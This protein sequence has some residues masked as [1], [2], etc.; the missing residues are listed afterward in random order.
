MENN[1]G[2]MSAKPSKTFL[3]PIECSGKE[4]PFKKWF[5]RTGPI[6]SGTDQRLYDL[7][8]FQIATSGMQANAVIGELW[9]T[10]CVKFSKPQLS[11]APTDGAALF[12]GKTAGWNNPGGTNTGVPVLLNKDSSFTESFNSLGVD[13]V[14]NTIA[15][16]ANVPNL[17][18]LTFP[19]GLTG[20]YGITLHQH[21]GSGNDPNVTKQTILPQLSVTNGTLV[22]AGWPTVGPEFQSNN[23][24]PSPSV[25]GDT[26]TT[27]AMQSYSCGTYASPSDERLPMIVEFLWSEGDTTPVG[28]ESSNS[29]MTTNIALEV[30]STDPNFVS[31]FSTGNPNDLYSTVRTRAE[32]PTPTLAH[33]SLLEEKKMED[34]EWETVRRMEQQATYNN[35]ESPQEIIGQVKR[36]RIMMSRGRTLGHT[37][38]THYPPK[39]L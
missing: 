6:P 19:A 25:A 33:L 38:S 22:Q 36:Q 12:L 18:T 4:N 21:I 31:G 2:T 20:S 14:P 35:R 28:G 3:F 24:W 1:E 13:Y 29:S 32:P 26:G 5:I 10:Y 27:G 11:P 15:L 23:N 37:I 17:G 34:D 30:R 8:N 7:C 39:K 16:P 9:V